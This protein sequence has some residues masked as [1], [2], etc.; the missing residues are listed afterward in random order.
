MNS[1]LQARS[2]IFNPDGK[3][4]H[5]SVGYVTD[6]FTGDT[7]AGKGAVFGLYEV[8]GE[9]LDASVGGKVFGLLQ[10]ITS[11]LPSGI[12]PKS[13]SAKE[14]IPSWWKDK[15]VGNEA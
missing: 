10:K 3:I 13:Y 2:F 15:R 1:Y 7:T 11:N 5:Q 12:L 9:S 4:K 14:D 8:I 6:R